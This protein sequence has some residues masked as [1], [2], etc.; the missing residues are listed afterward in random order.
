MK[1]VFLD[2]K[3]E[4]CQND[5][6]TQDNLQIQCN[7]CQTTNGIFHRTRT[8][9]FKVRMEACTHILSLCVVKAI[10]RKKSR[11]G[12]ARLTTDYT[13]KLQWGGTEIDPHTCG[14][15]IDVEGGESVYTR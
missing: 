11:H 7:S 6:T 5:H 10:L 8:K 2:W 15:F 1:N 3:N 14:Q 13:T 9:H 12:Q 4:H